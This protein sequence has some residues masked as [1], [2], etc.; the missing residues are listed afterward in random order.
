[1]EIQK[2]RYFFTAAKLGHIT[3]AAE[4]LYI[5]QP[6]LSQAIHSLEK[7]LGVPL[8]VKKG[9]NIVLTEYGEFLQKRLE[10]I[11]P[12]IDG[13]GDEIDHMK[14]KV[15]KTVRLN[16]LAAS[17]FII[18]TIVEYRKINPDVIFDFEQ[19]ESKDNNDIVITTNGSRASSV[20]PIERHI[21]DESIYIA[22]PVG[23]KYAKNDS[24][25]LAELKDEWF[26]MLSN[27]R[28]FG[29]I[30]NNFC[31]NV[32]FFPK[33]LFESDS[34]SA[35]QSMIGTGMGV[36]FWPEYSWGQAQNKNTVLLPISKP[37][38][39]RELIIELY[40]R[41]TQ[42]EYAKNFYDFLLRKFQ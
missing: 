38:C 25:E 9:R 28:L 15:N 29:V 42:S 37:I 12:E 10:Q 41:K 21:M 33:V 23:S 2:L 18:N 20:T 26:I 4:Y 34:P 27:S 19:N 31:S 7:E 3:K 1:M 30:C 35:V 6:S 14:Q 22:V 5:S 39:R 13:L 36:A 8:F 11:L 16:I 40:P 24:V 32:G 17:T